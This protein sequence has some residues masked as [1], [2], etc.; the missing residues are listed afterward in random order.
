MKG[1]WFR[2]FGETRIIG[3]IVAL[4]VALALGFWAAVVA[5]VAHFW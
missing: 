1:L 2:V 5:V 4:V 3:W